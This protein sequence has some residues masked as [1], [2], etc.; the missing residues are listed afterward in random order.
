MR[1]CREGEQSERGGRG[2][3]EPWGTPGFTAR[4][5]MSLLRALGRPSQP[6][7]VGSRTQEKWAFQKG[8]RNQCQMLLK[9][10]IRWALKKRLS[11][12][13]DFGNCLSGSIVRTEPMFE[14]GEGWVSGEE[15]NGDKQNKAK[16][17]VCEQ[18]KQVNGSRA[19]R[20]VKARLLFINGGCR[21]ASPSLWLQCAW[22]TT[23][24]NFLKNWT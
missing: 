11:V 16:R 6:G 7:S 13:K 12:T 14:L 19:R 1:R 2:R 8:Q 9:G 15:G 5:G 4:R 23:S 10:Q 18:G 22:H 3:A 24:R 21:D 20:G 17:L